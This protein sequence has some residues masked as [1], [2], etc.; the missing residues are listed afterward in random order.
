MKERK[1]QHK[2]VRIISYIALVTGVA[3]FLCGILMVPAVGLYVINRTAFISE[4]F[5]WLTD[6]AWY[7]SRLFDYIVIPALI[8]TIATLSIE[9]NKYYQLLPGM[10]VLIGHLLYFVCYTILD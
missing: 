4:R 9:R 3:T 2:A 8:L 1:E 5:D 7:S 6:M 10:F